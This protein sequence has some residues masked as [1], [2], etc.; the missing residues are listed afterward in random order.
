MVRGFSTQTERK[1]VATPASGFRLPKEREGRTVVGRRV[2]GDTDIFT[3][4]K[5]FNFELRR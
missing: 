2:Y 1:V 4:P 3:K 5:N